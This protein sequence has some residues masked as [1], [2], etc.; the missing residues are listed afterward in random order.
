MRNEDAP[1]SDAITSCASIADALAAI[2]GREW[3]LKDEAERRPYASDDLADYRAPPLPVVLPTSA[4]EVRRILARC[5]EHGIKVVP[6]GSG[7]SQSGGTLPPEEGIL[8]GTSRMNQI[9]EVHAENRVTSGQPGRQN[10]KL[11]EPVQHLGLCFM[12]DP[13]SQVIAS[14]SRNVAESRGGVHC[15]NFCSHSVLR[16]LS[17]VFAREDGEQEFLRAFVVTW[18]KVTNLDRF[19]TGTRNILPR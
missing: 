4:D 13:S 10:A 18:E 5:H 15:F 19:N 1:I 3:V 11:T 14:I 12:P 17:E 2:V 16:T 6:R 9:L 8:L 7:T